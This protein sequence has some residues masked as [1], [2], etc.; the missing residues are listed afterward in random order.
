VRAHSLVREIVP[1][2]RRGEPLTQDL[3][4]L[5]ELVASGRL[6]G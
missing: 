6:S 5:R 1:P 4:P 2:L 3:E